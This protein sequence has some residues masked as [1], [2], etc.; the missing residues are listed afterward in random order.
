MNTELVKL[1]HQARTIITN[2]IIIIIASSN[3]LFYGAG[4]LLTYLGF[5]YDEK[6]RP[7]DVDGAEVDY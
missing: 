4:S 2:L 1:R 7:A 3:Q 5:S 6:A